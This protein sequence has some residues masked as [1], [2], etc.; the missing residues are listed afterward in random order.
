M[1]L[2]TTKKK[3]KDIKSF[4]YYKT[5]FCFLLGSIVIITLM[6]KPTIIANRDY[7]ENIISANELT[8]RLM[9]TLNKMNNKSDGGMMLNF[10][11]DKI[12]F[13]VKSDET[14]NLKARVLEDYNY[15]NDS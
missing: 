10:Q 3:H 11:S 14:I 1:I 4:K 7:I 9:G 13:Y 12:L 2:N 15:D 8:S 5:I 6:P